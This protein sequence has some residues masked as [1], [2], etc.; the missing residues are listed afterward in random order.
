MS[1]KVAILGFGVEGRAA[2]R[3]FHEQGAV[4]T[5]LD[6]KQPT[7]VPEGVEVEVGPDIFERAMGYD[8]VVRT[9]SIR[10]D[11]IATDGE[12]T[13]G[14]KEFFKVCPVPI[15][16]V[17]A[18]KGKGTT[19]TLIARM[20]EASGI[21]AHLGGNIGI[22]M[23]ELLPHIKQ[24]DIVVLELSSFQLWDLTQSPHIAVVG[25]IEPDHLDVHKDF[26]EYI[27]AKANI[28]KWQTV[29]DIVVYH[30]TNEFSRKIAESSAGTKLRFASN[31]GAH[32]EG[33]VLVIDGHELC[34][35]AD[36]QIPGKHNIDNICAAATAV[37]QHVQDPAAIGRAI[38]EY[39]GLE[40]RIELVRELDRV[41]YYDD[42]FAAA[43][44]A[45]VVAARAFD[46][47]KIMILGGY[48]KQVDLTE[49]AQQ[50]A[51][52]NIK[53]L[54][55]IGQ[56]APRLAELFRAEGIAEKIE[57][58]GAPT[59]SA[60]VARAHELAEAGDIV[61]LSPGCASFDMFANYKDRGDQFKAAVEAL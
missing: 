15:I 44:G 2:W 54:L 61:L 22:P 9:P 55:L 39:R 3:Y 32:I 20:L 10:P 8:V 16:G 41:K 38:K 14:T 21:T 58:L 45:A 24:G 46:K 56:T 27:S 53:K 33:E 13:S 28:A 47:P 59:M 35:V 6:Q 52:T 43:P 36:I 25:M 57:E 37:W 23:L 7:D 40:H 4:I 49:M 48:D 11:R 34:R 19:A 26:A 5:I 60:L 51:K 12:I 17:T 18:S 1:Q 29:D 30:P 50:I 31:E 42:S